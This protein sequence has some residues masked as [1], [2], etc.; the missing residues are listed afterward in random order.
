[1][2]NVSSKLAEPVLANLAELGSS[3]LYLGGWDT[4]VGHVNA[5]TGANRGTYQHV[6]VLPTTNEL[7]YVTASLYDMSLLQPAFLHA[8]VVCSMGKRVREGTHQHRNSSALSTR[9]ART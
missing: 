5:A 8:V 9:C 4:H 7:L 6:T 3:G 1:M 2:R